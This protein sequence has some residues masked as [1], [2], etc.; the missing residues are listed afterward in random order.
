MSKSIIFETERIILRPIEISDAENIFNNYA[1]K[2]NVTKYLTWKSHKS[3]DDTVSYLQNFVIPDYQ[4][5]KT[6]RWAIVLK[7]TNEVIGCI[8]VVRYDETKQRAEL[9]WV[10]D[11][12]HWGKGIMP[13]A[14]KIVLDYLVKEG[15]KRIQAFH[16][17]ENPKSG[18]VMEK[19]G[20]QYE[21]TLKKYAHSNDKQLIDV[22]LYAYVC[23]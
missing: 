23:D 12:S 3:L 14:G 20:M 18:R 6:Y 9:G 5:E 16:D 11:D 7:E 17:I 15:F 4:N 10:L 21:G 1:S 13:E 2:D 8:D 19:I 22:K